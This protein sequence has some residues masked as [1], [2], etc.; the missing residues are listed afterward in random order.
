M[1]PWQAA[2]RIEPNSSWRPTAKPRPHEPHDDPGH[3]RAGRRPDQPPYGEI[4]KPNRRQLLAA[5]ELTS[6]MTSGSPERP[7]P[8]RP[9]GQGRRRPGQGKGPPRA[10]QRA[11]G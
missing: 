4:T 1:L 11:D 10:V 3:A 8:R 5:F 7:R 6:E 2:T 9:R